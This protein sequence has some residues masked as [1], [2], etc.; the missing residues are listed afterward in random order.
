MKRFGLSLALASSLALAACASAT[1]SLPSTAVMPPG[2][3]HT[4]GDI[5][6]RALNVA[7]NDFGH[8]RA[9]QGDPARA[10]D[11][12]AALDYMGGELNTAPRWVAMPSI[13]RLNMLR[14]RE[15]VRAQLGISNEVPSQA[16]VDTMLGLSN[17]YRAGDE[18]Q[19]AKLLAS[20]I[21]SLPPAQTAQRLGDLPYMAAVANATSHA[22]AYATAPTY[23]GG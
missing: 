7:A 15:A 11:A 2:A 12:V 20:P 5:D 22:A 13:F 6:V 10:A 1:D 16:V 3:L 21:F 23:S 14:S 17:A 18:A 8:W 19:V 9:M 4:N